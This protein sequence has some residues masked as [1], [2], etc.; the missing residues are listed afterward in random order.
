MKKIRTAVIGLGVGEAH[1]ET[2]TSNRNSEVV[3]ICDLSPKRLT[4]LHERFPQ[5]ER[6]T[7]NAEEIL[8][9]SDIDLVSICSYDDHHYDQ[10]MLGLQHNKHLFVEKPICL[11]LRQLESIEA[12]LNKCS[13][14]KFSSNLILRKAPRFIDL[15]RRIENN[16]FGQFY[17]LEGD[18]NFGRLSKITDGWRG[19]IEGY[20]GIL[21]GGVH[22]IDLIL[23]LSQ[24][25][26]IEVGACGSKLMTKNSK[27][28][29]FDCTVALL[30]FRS[31]AVG[32]LCCNLGS[33]YPHFHR[34]ALY[35]TKASFEQI[36]GRAQIFN[37]CD[38]Q[39]SS[40]IIDSDYPA[41]HKGALLDN[42]IDAVI[43]NRK[44]EV[45]PHEIFTGM[46]VCLAIEEAAHTNKSVI[47]E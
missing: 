26:I 21:G 13:N 7:S 46:R 47:L 14:L 10:V 24:D 29:N 33:I 37:S 44:P 8:T 4:Q 12:T 39:D 17:Y 16:D 3:A 23:W 31:G 20:S 28:K 25:Q 41:V 43:E 6:V 27:F 2:F 18:Y 35:G 45:P 32:K 5:V 1:L 34:L 30:K 42:F 11:T 40:S 22:I 9:A 38:P 15:K 19:D 36:K